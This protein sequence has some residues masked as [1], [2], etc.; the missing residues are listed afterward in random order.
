M[1][2][3]PLCSRPAV[4]FNRAAV[5]AIFESGFWY[6]NGTLHTLGSH[7]VESWLSE[8]PYKKFHRYIN[9]AYRK[10]GKGEIV[11]IDWE[12]LEKSFVPTFTGETCYLL[13]AVPCGHCELCQ[14]RRQNDFSARCNMEAATSY[15]SP[16]MVTLTYDRHHLPIEKKVAVHHLTSDPDRMYTTYE[17][18]FAG[19]LSELYHLRKNDMVRR[20]VWYKKDVQMFLDRLRHRWVRSS[21]VPIGYA[22]ILSADDPTFAGRAAAYRAE[23]P[24]RYVC[25]A[26]YGSKRGRPHYHL[27][28]YNVPYEIKSQFDFR[29]IAQLKSDILSAWGMCL[30]WQRSEGFYDSRSVQCEVARD[31]GK[32]VGKYLS[33][34][35]KN[36][37]KG[38]CHCSSRGG[39]IGAK[40]IDNRSDFFHEHPEENKIRF[41]NRLGQCLEYTLGRYATKRLFPTKSAVVS[42]ESKQYYRKACSILSDHA[43]VLRSFH[44]DERTIDKLRV[45]ADR[46]NP[47]PG[48][49][50]SSFSTHGRSPLPR[51]ARFYELDQIEHILC[52]MDVEQ[53]A[54]LSA[55]VPRY[56]FR[57][58]LCVDELHRRHSESIPLRVV[59]DDVVRV[60][61][62]RSM[63]MAHDAALREVF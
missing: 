7:Q 56:D 46:L 2:P 52:V 1:Y 15:T 39:G 11:G 60:Q 34:P 33:K 4:I 38:F 13:L 3:R 45:L 54:L 59:N 61:S 8:F 19:R 62:W 5:N 25:V 28:L 17:W 14:E 41:V 44:V 55:E 27:I 22:S 26:E 29:E 31:A 49:L 58:L 40:L 16:V 43:R 20:M 30:M 32:Y 57:D 24:F 35:N 53:R 9:S 37:R 18:R 63:R 47:A 6:L 50:L 42:D 23:Y 10:N 51:P 48:V 36:G 12:F 21:R